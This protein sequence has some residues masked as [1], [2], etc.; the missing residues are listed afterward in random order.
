MF[1]NEKKIGLALG[2][3]GVRALSSIGV[4]RYLRKNNVP[5]SA[6]A[7]TSMGSVVG[8]MY[9]YYQ[10]I[11]E[12]ENRIRMCLSTEE[13]KALSR[14]FSDIIKNVSQP[15]VEKNAF[16][17]RFQ[18]YF[19][20]V[21]FVNKFLGAISLIKREMVESV[22]NYLIPDVDIRDL[23]IKFCSVSA[24]IIDGKMVAIQEGGLRKAIMG[25]IALPGIMI[26]EKWGDMLLIDGG[27]VRMTPIEE[28][29]KLGVDSVIAIEVMGKLRQKEYFDNGMEII[30]RASKITAKEL[31]TLHLTKADVVVSPAVKNI[32]WANFKKIDY[33]IAAGE[34]AA[35][36][37]KSL[38]KRKK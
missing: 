7:G 27:Y 32:Y 8:G 35:Y 38:S 23:H 15:P 33:C 5:I 29:R 18:R 30:E 11:D 2:G 25:T 13:Y 20:Q 22:I 17:E 14:E 37:L 1:L 26:P 6:I 36:D 34:A 21:Y 9:A 24:N 28:A 19:S 3:G 12:V 31:H 10:D 4:I 16:K